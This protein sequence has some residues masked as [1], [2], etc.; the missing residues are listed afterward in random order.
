LFIQSSTLQQYTGYKAAD[1]RECVLIVHDLYLSRRGGGLQAV[2][3]KY[4]QHKVWLISVKT[5]QDFELNSRTVKRHFVYIEFFFWDSSSAWQTCLPRQS[6]QL[7]ISKRFK[8]NSWPVH[9]MFRVM[10]SDGNCY[11]LRKP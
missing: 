9:Y 10:T 4:K 8:C 2:R 3:E 11:P 7:Y 5:T 1:L 6:Y